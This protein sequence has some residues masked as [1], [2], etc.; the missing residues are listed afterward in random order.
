MAKKKNN[1]SELENEASFRAGQGSGLHEA[2]TYL[3]EEAKRFFACE[4]DETARDFR[5]ASKKLLKRAD[6]EVGI[7]REL[8]S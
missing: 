2:A 5:D 4:K 7:A 8:Q 1:E 3:M 6:V